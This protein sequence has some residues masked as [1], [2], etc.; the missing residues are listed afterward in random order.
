[1][2]D[3]RVRIGLIVNPVAGMGG[4]V[5]L[6]GTDGADVLA[7]ARALGSEARAGERARQAMALLAPLADRFTLLTAA[8]AMGAD[9]ARAAGLAAAIVYT[10]PSTTTAADTRAAAEALRGVDLLLF[11]GGDG[12]ARDVESVL[13]EATP[14][15]GI[16]AG[17][18]MHSGVFATSP[19]AAGRLV[20]TLLESADW[21]RL[22]LRKAEVMDID[23]AA[24]R[25]NRLSARLYGYLAVPEARR[26]LQQPKQGGYTDDEQSVHD[27]A[28][29]LA[30]ELDPA[31]GYV[32][33]PG[34]SAKAVLDTLGLTGTLL[35]VDLLIDGRI[36]GRDIGDRM[37][38]DRVGARPVRIIAG[39]TG[40]QGFLFG[41]GNQQIAPEIIRRAGR[42]GLLVI[43]GRQ[44]LA[45]LTDG[46]LLVD[47][48][49]PAL[50]RELEGYI[51]VRC[52]ATE[53]MLMRVEAA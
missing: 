15:V 12:T 47:T 31:V 40:G 1:M 7:R 33:G 46:R 44:K 4:A 23:E 5:G 19:L 29:A 9:A 37:L 36:V 38:I 45:H 18:K 20:A 14:A 50:D 28:Q 2:T 8:G 52:G 6:K 17:V 41:R 22:S 25:N 3:Q 34:R 13:G 53:W 10:P 42:D 51:R 26:L 11:C 43:A 30:R 48:G 27:A 35:G 21:R 24:F 16:P 49:D 32:V 39:I